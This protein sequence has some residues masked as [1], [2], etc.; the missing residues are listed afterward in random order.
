MMVGQIHASESTIQENALARLALETASE[1][2]AFGVESCHVLI[3]CSKSKG[4]HRD[5]ARNMYV[6][7]LYRKSVLTAEGWGVPFSILSAK[8]GLLDPDDEI[9]PYDLTLKGKAQS[10]KAEWAS[11]VTAQILDQFGSKRNLIVL[12]GD[13]YL[14]PLLTFHE[15]NTPNYLAPMKGLSL[16]NRLSFLNHCIQ[17]RRRKSDIARA[18]RLFERISKS[19]GLR[20]LK[21][22]LKHDV[23][24]KG[25]YFFFDGNEETAFSNSIPRLVRIGTHGVSAGSTS[26]LRT[27]LRTHFGTQ[28]G[29]GNHRAS[30][31]RLH[32]GRA[33]IER[34]GLQKLFPHWGKG[35]S[36]KKTISQSEADLERQVSE[37][38]GKL[39][40][41]YVPII[42][43]SGVGSSRALIERQFIALFSENLCPLETPSPSWLGRF[44][45]KSTIRQTGLWNVRDVGSE[46]DPKFIRY[47]ESILQRPLSEKEAR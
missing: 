16:G 2:Q 17:L 46:Y 42:D 3:A 41:L 11:R 39:S 45:D 35:Q 27:R 14:K 20:E 38:I 12:A 1:I 19:T 30:V 23:P 5:I 15:A 13:D 25:V 24:K 4:T 47:F 40:V 10:F 22:L 31:F 7:S 33:I 36:A 21:H 37:Y 34:E 8:Y 26:T 43:E 9:E 44:S 28:A 29:I 18:Y 6:S 32:V